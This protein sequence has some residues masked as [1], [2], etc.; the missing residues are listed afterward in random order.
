MTGGSAREMEMSAALKRCR[1]NAEAAIENESPAGAAVSGA[2]L[3]FE[4]ATELSHTADVI[5]E[6]LASPYTQSAVS[7]IEAARC[8]LNSADFVRLREEA[9]EIGRRM[10]ELMKGKTPAP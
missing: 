2:A 1:R 3:C 5:A 10:F 8:R 7:E 9:S 6:F 4:K